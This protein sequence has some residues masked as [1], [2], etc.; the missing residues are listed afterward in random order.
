MVYREFTRPGRF[1]SSAGVRERPSGR[2]ATGPYLSLY[3]EGFQLLFAHGGQG[4]DL[5]AEVQFHKEERRDCGGGLEGR[6]GKIE[7][8]RCVL[9]EFVG[10]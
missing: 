4:K 3:Y 8:N 5:F 1:S 6:V 9:G 7:G 2:G 10:N